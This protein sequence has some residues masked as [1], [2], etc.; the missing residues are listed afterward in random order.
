MKEELL[1]KYFTG[2]C[3]FLA[4]ALNDTFGWEIRANVDS[5]DD[6]SWIDHAWVVNKCGLAVDIDGV[7]SSDDPTEFNSELKYNLTKGC[8]R[9][10]MRMS[11]D[12]FNTHLRDAMGVVENY[13]NHFMGPA[14][15]K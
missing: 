3:M 9:E 7:H 1:G 6:G 12:E 13:R 5:D 15:I 14:K 4:V 8:I 11:N 2:Y 10:I